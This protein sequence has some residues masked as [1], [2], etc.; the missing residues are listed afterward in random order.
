[1]EDNNSQQIDN[2]NDSNTNINYSQGQNSGKNQSSDDFS[3]LFCGKELTSYFNYSKLEEE[4]GEI[5][6]KFWSSK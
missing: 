2:Q 4:F 1:M 6:K 3:A 5:K